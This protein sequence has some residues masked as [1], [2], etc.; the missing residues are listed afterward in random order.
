MTSA[1][2][3]TQLGYTRRDGQRSRLYLAI[4]QPA[5][6]FA[7][8]IN[9]VFALAEDKDKV[10]AVLYDNVTTGAYTDVLEGM[11]CYIGS[12]PGA[13]DLGMVRMRKVPT[14]DTIY[15][16]ENSDAGWA[17]DVYITVVDEFGLWAKYPRLL[18]DGSLFMDYDIEYVDQ[19]TAFKPVV[20]MGSDA[21]LWLNGVDVSIIFDAS[22]SWCFSAGEK[23]YLW[24]VNGG[25]VVTDEDTDTP[26]FTFDIPGVYRV[27]CTVTV[28][29]VSSTGYRHVFVYSDENPPISAGIANSSRG[30]SLSSAPTGEMERGGWEFEVVLYKESA[31]I[32]LVRDGAQ[33]ILFSRDWYGN[34]E[35]C[36]GAQ[37]GRENI[38]CA[39]WIA[40]ESIVMNGVEGTAYFSVKGPHYF[41]SALASFIDGIESN[42][43]D[44]DAWTAMTGLTVDKAIWHLLEWRSTVTTIMDFYPSNDTHGAKSLQ[45]AQGGLLSQI[46]MNSEPVLAFPR[47]DR[48]GRMFVEV[49]QQLI[50]YDDRAAFP[51]VLTLSKQDWQG[52]L[53]ITRNT[54]SRD[55]RIELS[56][57]YYSDADSPLA[58][59]ALACGH[60]FKRF[61]EATS[62]ERLLISD[63]DEAN[64]WA[65]LMLGWKN[66]MY[67]F[68]IRSGGNNCMVD[69]AP[70]QY[71]GLSIATTDTPRGI[72]YSGRMV[73][74]RVTME[75]DSNIGFISHTWSGDQESYP[76]NSITGD[77]PPESTVDDIDISIPPLPP[78]VDLP[79][80]DGLL[81]L[82]PT[83]V[84]TNQP[85]TVVSWGSMGVSYTT[86]FNEDVPKW[87]F[88]NAGLSELDKADIHSV[89]R[90]PLGALYLLTSSG[91]EVWR[92]STLGG[93]WI[94]I[95]ASGDFEHGVLA[96]G[97]LPTVQ[98]TIIIIG[99]SYFAV[100][101]GTESGDV[102][103]ATGGVLGGVGG[104][105]FLRYP[106]GA[107]VFSNGK[108]I[109]FG[110]AG[111]FFSTPFVQT[112][113]TSGA[114]AYAGSIETATGQDAAPRYANV[115]GSGDVV[116]EW[117]GA[118][119][120]G[121]NVITD[122]GVTVV[123]HT[124][125]TPAGNRQAISFSPTG[126][127]AMAA[128]SGS[129]VYI[130]TDGGATWISA[131]GV[132]PT[133]IVALD[134]CGDDYRWVFAGGSVIRLTMDQGTSYVDKTGNLV[135]IA[136]LINIAGVLFIS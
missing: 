13:Y 45:T 130:T 135:V 63:Q 58:I 128:N 104:L 62:L 27:S 107:V 37:S 6:V 25:A 82:P 116:Y 46:R 1:L 85:T 131:G 34:D 20:I 55:A 39:G 72:A 12:T 59:F 2:S 10:N 91:N 106:R 17:D 24:T 9:Q 123:R 108:F 51:T 105:N 88:M 53:F 86:N 78:F 56:G 32:S 101:P 89:I 111:G 92:C 129:V 83:T 119:P 132:I 94:R 65:G 47:F 31:D 48:Y 124:T 117:D 90:T 19:H 127:K 95:V 18:A 41:I 122:G 87:E 8:Q 40:S 14:V 61:G 112:F 118:G 102:R 97:V 5:V 74:R 43:S 28:D 16:G 69:I 52:D 38:K 79:P 44:P 30:F 73:P 4:H 80:L 68:E 15:P 29:G 134:N 93:T 66:R 26:T 133:G 70:R 120:G 75:F 21:V 7:A 84:P 114:P 76:E 64:R 50:P 98:D 57:V 60:V 71:V 33:V 115:G 23:I 103:I 109:A 49:E 96:I 121:Y 100:G 126:I 136:P 3:P 35:I 125:L 11:T 110:S 113:S 54:M 42:A 22:P 81:D 36:I 77:F 67:D 99:S